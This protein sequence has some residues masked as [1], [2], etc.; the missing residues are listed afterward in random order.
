LCFA[1]DFTL[2]SLP[3]KALPKG[4]IDSMKDSLNDVIEF[5]NPAQAGEFFES[6]NKNRVGAGSGSIATT[7]IDSEVTEDIRDSMLHAIQSKSGLKDF[8]KD[9]ADNSNQQVISNQSMNSKES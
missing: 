7:L 8:K 3:Q 6:W 1:S 2:L 4:A 9:G 5:E